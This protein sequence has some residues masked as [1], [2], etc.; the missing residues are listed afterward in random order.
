MYLVPKL[1]R[2]V[3]ALFMFF[4]FLFSSALRWYGHIHR[5][6]DDDWVKGSM[7]FVVEG[8]LPRGRLKRTWNEVI[9]MI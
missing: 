6:S 1:Y 9:R 5:K 4:S 8:C 7:N 2:I 3:S